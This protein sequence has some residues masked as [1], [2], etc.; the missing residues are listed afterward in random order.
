MPH[1]LIMLDKPVKARYVRIVNDRDIEGR[2]S[3]FDLRLFGSDGKKVLDRKVKHTVLR[4]PDD[5]RRITVRW[6]AVP[7]AERYIVRWGIAGSGV[8]NNSAEVASDTELEAGWYNRDSDY[9]FEVRAY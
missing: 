5:R 7:H 4:N 9:D 6:D 3:L 2:F 8:L 1:E